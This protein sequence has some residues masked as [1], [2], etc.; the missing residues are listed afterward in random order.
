METK[1]KLNKEVIATLNDDSMNRVEGG[2]AAVTPLFTTG[3]T[4][5]CG[6]L[7]TMWR[8]TKANCT[9]DC[10][11]VACDTEHFCTV[12]QNGYDNPY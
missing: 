12:C 7:G 3:C 4:D 8:C 10:S 2:D 11:T 9:A 6:T 5:G 1:L